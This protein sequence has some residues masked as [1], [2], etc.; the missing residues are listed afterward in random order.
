M[1]KS[2]LLRLT[3]NGKTVGVRAD[4]ILAVVPQTEGRG[5][6][7]LHIGGRG[8]TR[9]ITVTEEPEQVLALMDDVLGFA[10]RPIRAPN[11]LA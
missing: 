2:P 4:V 9:S 11:T 3:Q 5:G 6:S 8:D 10:N 7:I 1:M